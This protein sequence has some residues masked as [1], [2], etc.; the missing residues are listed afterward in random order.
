MNTLLSPP[1]VQLPHP[2]PFPSYYSTLP[3]PHL[4]L[5][6]LCHFHLW[7]LNH[8]SDQHNS[9]CIYPFNNVPYSHF[10]S[11]QVWSHFSHLHP[12]KQNSS[13]TPPSFPSISCIQ[14]HS[15]F[16]IF[17]PYSPLSF[18]SISILWFLPIPFPSDHLSKLRFT[19]L[20][21]PHP[22]FSMICNNF[23]LI[24][25]H[26]HISSPVFSLYITLSILPMW[27]NFVNYT[28]IIYK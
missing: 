13:S 19:L 3:L 28:I 18:L 6:E 8:N 11:L 5:S 16:H 7:T 1:L 24:R 22:L 21:A 10:T 20:S 12:P 15:T 26:L 2:P 4:P 25:T 17:I 9:L 23:F 14:P 27:Q